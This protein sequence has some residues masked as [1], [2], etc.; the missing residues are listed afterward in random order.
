MELA[1]L[2]ESGDFL[3]FY[4]KDCTIYL[5]NSLRRI[6][7]S[8]IPIWAI[9]E[10]KIYKNTTALPDEFIGHRLGLIP[11][12]FMKNI[13]SNTNITFSFK[14]TAEQDIEEWTSDMLESNNENIIPAIDNIPIVKVKKGQELHFTAI[15]KLDI[16]E[17]H[18]KWSPVTT[19]THFKKTDNGIIFNVY[20]I[21]S[22]EPKEIVTEAINILKQKLKNFIDKTMTQ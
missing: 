8:E 10:V 9:E 19:S 13:D 3:Q 12:T 1:I 15:A 6:M 5:A 21:G 20:T 18:S 2:K 14:K 11:L 16:G 7:I 17:T 22:I 4:I